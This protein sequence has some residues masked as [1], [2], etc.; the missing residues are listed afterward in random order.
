[1]SLSS[2]RARAVSHPCEA[3]IN[4]NGRQKRQTDRVLHMKCETESVYSSTG[5]PLVFRDT[6]FLSGGRGPGISSGGRGGSELPFVLSS[7]RN[8]YL[9][10][11]CRYLFRDLPQAYAAVLGKQCNSLGLMKVKHFAPPRPPRNALYRMPRPA[12]DFRGRESAVRDA[13]MTF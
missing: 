11:C 6:G 7:E 9:L 10:V 1:V 2:L 8:V 13:M 3:A 5:D 4:Y 12:T